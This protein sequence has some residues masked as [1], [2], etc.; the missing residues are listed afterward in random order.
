[1]RDWVRTPFFALYLRRT[2]LIWFGL[3]VAL[4]FITLMGNAQSRAFAMPAPLGFRF[5]AEAGMIVV[6]CLL[7]R[8]LMR[9]NGEDLLLGNLGLPAGIVFTQVILMS[10]LLSWLASLLA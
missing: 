7:M 5:G 2:L 1:L 6:A 4:V 8:G 9:R 3:K 10:P